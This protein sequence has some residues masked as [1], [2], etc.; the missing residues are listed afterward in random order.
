[1]F[2]SFY[3]HWPFCPYKCHFCP[4]IA[5]AFKGQES[6]MPQYHD[7]LQKELLAF[8]DQQGQ[9]VDVKTIYFGGGTPSTYPDDLLLDT[10][11]TLRRVSNFDDTTEITIEV[12]PGTANRAKLE[13]WKRLGVNRLSIG[14]QSLNEK[15]LRDINR[16]QVNTDIYTVLDDAKG[17]FD[18]VNVDLI[19]GLPNI[20]SIQWKEQVKSIMQWPIKHIAVYFLTV[21]EFTPLYYRIK[22]RDLLLPPDEEIVDLYDWTIE[23]LKRYGFMQYEVSNFAREGFQS[24]HNKGYW[25]RKPY[26]GFGVGAWSFDG[27]NR[28]M[29]RKNLSLYMKGAQENDTI[30]FSETLNNEQ[31]VLESIM[32]SLRQKEGLK[33][34]DYY[35]FV[36]SEKYDC[37]QEQIEQLKGRGLLVERDGRLQLTIKGLALEQEIIAKISP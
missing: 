12:N 35:R 30:E 16:L 13:H 10:F 14:V 6:Y 20:S 15:V 2:N 18:N 34:D 21:H 24:V 8:H 23:Y 11:G 26:R 32:L 22:K 3:I 1:M 28:F 19:I 31:V 5:Y 9:K 4:F 7:A 29:N 27:S 37:M 36:G 17:L 25:Q 33:T